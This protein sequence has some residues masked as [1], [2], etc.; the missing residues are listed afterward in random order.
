MARPVIII[1][2]QPLELYPPVMNLLDFMYQQHS[3]KKVVVLTNSTNA[4][5]SRF[6]INNNNIVIKRLSKFESKQSVFK[7][8]LNYLT[9]YSICLLTLIKKRPAA[10]LYFETLSSYPVWIYKK[11]IAK[12]VPVFIHYHEYTSPLEYKTGMRLNR[13][14]HEKEKWLYPRAV[15][16]SHTNEQRLKFFLQDEGI[17]GKVP[18]FVLPNFPNGK[19][20][21]KKQR[22]K[23][24]PIRIVYVGALSLKTMYLEAFI[25]WVLKN[26]AKVSF[27]IYSNNI[28]E[29][30][31]N[32]IKKIKEE[33]IKLHG[34]VPYQQLPTILKKYDVG[35]ILYNG[36]IPNYIFNAPNKLFEYLACGLD[37]WAPSIMVGCSQYFT[38][39]SFPKV[40]PINFSVPISF[41]PEIG[42][43]TNGCIYKEP[44]FYCENVLPP[45][46]QALVKC[47]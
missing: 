38:N 21:N 8:C 32:F 11:F 47:T 1:H 6:T 45:L 23:G 7:R 24:L 4:D 16:I 37:V 43:N 40:I 36:H 30:A 25:Q 10:I 17:E 22:N 41:D 19:W 26:K 29:D 35:V 31:Q 5:V 9:F 18:A 34:G 28:E 46:M 44:V 33:A 39:G 13:F 42:F 27:D 2:F 12:R 14:F 20:K 15:W 3:S